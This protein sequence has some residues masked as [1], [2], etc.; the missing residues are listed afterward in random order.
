MDKAAISAKNHFFSVKSHIFYTK[1][2]RES[3]HEDSRTAWSCLLWSRDVRVTP[4]SRCD[5]ALTTGTDAT[6]AKTASS[7]RGQSAVL[8][9]TVPSTSV[10]VMRSSERLWLA[11]RRC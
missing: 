5:F 11:A 6:I 3:S 10:V 2:A 4:T 1:A 9:N 8:V 7:I